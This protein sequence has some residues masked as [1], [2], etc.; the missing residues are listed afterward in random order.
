V[1]AKHR[2]YLCAPG[3]L[4]LAGSVSA[5]AFAADQAASGAG[6]EEIVVTAVRQALRDSSF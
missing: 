5:P 2:K 6:L 4:L 3:A 1:K